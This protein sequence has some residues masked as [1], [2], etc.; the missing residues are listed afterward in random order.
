MPRGDTLGEFEQ[1]VLLALLR[2]GDNAYGLGVQRELAA[3]AGR[4]ASIGAIYTTLDR[5]EV[6]GLVRSATGDSSAERGGRAK[7]IFQVTGAGRQALA[8]SMAATR[9]LAEGL[10][11]FEPA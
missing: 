2:L 1:L 7:R 9:S 10:K 5:L 8:D 11:G 6:K 4:Q 3:R